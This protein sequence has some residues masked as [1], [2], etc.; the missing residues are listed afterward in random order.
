M[1][2]T[3]PCHKTTKQEGFSY[4]GLP[5]TN[6]IGPPK[7]MTWVDK[8]KLHYRNQAIL[9]LNKGHAGIKNSRV[10]AVC[11]LYPAV[12]YGPPVSSCGPSVYT[13]C[14]RCSLAGGPRCQSGSTGLTKTCNRGKTNFNK[15]SRRF[16]L[17][18]VYSKA[19]TNNWSP[20]PWHT[21]PVLYRILYSFRTCRLQMFK[22]Y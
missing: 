19:E 21:R 17:K 12:C 8:P 9:F 7:E 20:L 1:I 14:P 4:W 18:N 11:L 10:P 5:N 2:C 16:I 15:Y 6:G 3:L 13:R 22:V